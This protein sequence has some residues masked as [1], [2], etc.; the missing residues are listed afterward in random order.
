MEGVEEKEMSPVLNDSTRMV[1]GWPLALFRITFGL[2]YLN[3]ALQKAPWITGPEGKP[4]GWLY[5]YIWKEINHP[6]FGWYTAFLKGVVLPNFGLFGLMSFLT[7]MALGVALVLGILIPLAGIGGAF[8]MVNIMLGSY[9]IP[10]EWGWIWMLL[11]APQAVFAFSGAGRVLGV[12]AWLE[13]LLR[14]R[15]ETGMGLARLLRYAS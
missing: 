2:M 14:Q 3:M 1:S 12:D 7:E 8:W 9:S 10:G 6:T 13:P 4:Y 11:I 5:G 15:A